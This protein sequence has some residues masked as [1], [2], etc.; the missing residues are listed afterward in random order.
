[1]IALSCSTTDRLSQS[2][3]L[4]TSVPKRQMR[5]ARYM[6]TAFLN[7]FTESKNMASDAEDY[8]MLGV[9]LVFEK[10]EKLLKDLIK[11]IDIA[12][13]DKEGKLIV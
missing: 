7:K 5:H 1:M 2:T 8:G 11:T 6:L 9:F 13:G 10:G 3:S 12:L 4:R